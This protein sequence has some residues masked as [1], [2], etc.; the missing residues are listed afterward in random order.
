MNLAQQLA[1]AE[2]RVDLLR[3][4]IEGAT[5]AEAGHDWRFIG[6]K[7]AGCADWCNCSVDVHECARC[8]DCDYG[9]TPQADEIRRACAERHPDI[10]A[11]IERLSR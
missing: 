5:C 3:R 7:N 4:Q 6:G 9:D 1:D 11:E 2:A 8:G 10:L